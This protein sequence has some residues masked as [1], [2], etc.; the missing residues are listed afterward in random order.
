MHMISS[1][2]GYAIVEDVFAPADMERVLEGLSSARLDRTKAGARHML[3]VRVVGDLAADPRMIAIAT[4]FVGPGAVPFSATLF[5]KSPGANWLVVWHQDTALPLRERF[6]DAAWGPWSVKAGI[7]YAHA[8]A[9]ALEGWWRCGSASTTRRAPTGHSACCP[10]PM[11]VAS[12]AMQ[13]SSNWPAA[14][15]PSTASPAGVASS[16]C[17]L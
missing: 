17:A 2:H 13:P 1:H 3:G 10:A 12:W 9:W 8:P 4:G 11:S 16:R 6:G 5:D 7:L 15:H 14:R